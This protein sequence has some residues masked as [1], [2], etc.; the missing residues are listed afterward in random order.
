MSGK[1]RT[2]GARFAAIGRQPLLHLSVLRP[3][4]FPDQIAPILSI[5]ILVT[6]A[7]SKNEIAA[8]E[9]GHFTLSR[10][11]K[12]MFHCGGLGNNDTAFADGGH[13]K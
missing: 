13:L 1:I 9:G 2:A 10:N 3:R 8:P 12:T 5:T 7:I 11:S 6:V 4:Q